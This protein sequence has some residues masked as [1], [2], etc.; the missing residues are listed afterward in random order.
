MFEPAKPSRRN[1]RTAS[2]NHPRPFG[3]LWPCL[4]YTFLA[5]IASQGAL[6]VFA[7]AAWPAQH[8]IVEGQTNISNIAPSLAFDIIQVVNALII[9]GCAI[10]YLRFHYRALRNLRSIDAPGVRLTPFWT[11]GRFAIPVASLWAP[12]IALRQ[13]W[14]GSMSPNT[15]HAKAPSYLG[16]WWAL[17]ITINILIGV[18]TKIQEHAHGAEAPLVAMSFAIAN[19][20]FFVLSALAVIRFSEEIKLAQDANLFKSEIG[21]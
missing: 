10:A 3:K 1:L 6:V 2:P 13:T 18:E 16:W 5:F 7:F 8:A 9:I 4:R 20:P 11:F 14:C 19:A 15:G 12:L 17:W 21:A